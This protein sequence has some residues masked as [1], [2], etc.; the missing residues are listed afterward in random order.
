MKMVRTAV[1]LVLAVAGIVPAQE[2][3]KTIP[4]PSSKMLLAPAPGAPQLTS[5]FSETLA[6]SPD[7]R[8]VAVLNNGYGSA[9][10]A[11]RQSIAILD[12]TTNQLRDFPDPRLGRR[13]RQTFFVGLAF[14]ADGK[15][16]YASMA[17]I[18][19]PLGERPGS[20]GNGIAVYSFEN[21]VVAPQGFL[22]IGL[23]PLRPGQR[24]A[25]VN[26]KIPAGQAI[27]Y[28]AGLA[29]IPGTP[30]KLLVADNLSDDAL[31]LDASDGKIL[32]RFALSTS[33][34]EL[35][36]SYPYAVVVDKVGERAWV[37]LWNASSVVELDLKKGRVGRSIA[38][39]KPKSNTQAGSHPTTMMWLGEGFLL[40]TL[41]NTDEVAVVRPDTGKVIKYLSTTLPKQQVGGAYPNSLAMD[42]EYLFV[43]NASSDA[44]AVFKTD[45]KTWICL[46]NCG[47]EDEKPPSFKASLLGFIPTEWYPT[48]LA[49]KDGDL[50]IATGKA[51][52][53]GPNK[54]SDPKKPT[55]IA[56]LLHGSI[57]RVNIADAL[58]NLPALTREVA[59]SNL[60]LADQQAF[61]F[62]SGQNPI[63]HVIYVIK[64]NRTYDQ[65]FGDLKWGDG[66]PSLVL[67]GEDVTPNHHKLARQFGILDNFYDS[68]EVSGDGHVWSTAAITSDY[69]EKTWQINYR[70]AERTYDFAG[71]VAG[72]IPLD[73]GIPD[74]NEPAT[75]YL[76]TNL[77]RHQL[78]Y[79]DYG[80]FVE[81]PWCNEKLPSK[82]PQQPP[83]LP[84]CP[85]QVVKPGEPLP[86]GKP[87]PWPWPVPLFASA[88]GT[89]PELRGH[90]DAHYAGWNLAYPDQLRADQFLQEFAQFVRDKN[91][92]QFILLYL[93]NDH[94]SGTTPGSQRPAAMVADNDLALGRVI[95]AVS[96]SPYWDD[97]A[98]FVIEDDAQNGGDHV[99]AHRSIA[100]VI[101][102]YSP[103]APD[104]PLVDHTF[105]TTVS[106]V[107]TMEA[108]LGLPPMNNN[109]A[110]APL[111]APLFAGPGT[112]PPFDA[113]F[114][115][116]KNGMIYEV[117]PPKAPG[118][119]ASAQM[120][121]SR[122]DAVDSAVLNQILW[123]DRR[124]DQVPPP[125]PRHNPKVHKVIGAA[126]DE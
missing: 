108:L 47:P 7:G 29:V 43:G 66:D 53:T 69:T 27:P 73:Q 28:P 55:Y 9:E 87:S 85:R 97:T 63:K 83:T 33:K 106:M 122:P 13:A 126:E 6:V 88:E 38:L 46:D 32:K 18:T 4:L 115:N 86:D 15:R 39:H 121:Y 19:D 104:Q 125:T 70:G 1:A 93:P 52:G 89:K 103:G 2:Q 120:D 35:P 67:Y 102:K 75:G 49:V 111:M 112:Q 124:G 5:S 100:L 21:G 57:A 12:L 22:K 42:K 48:A 113:D 24:F 59:E 71:Q 99:D 51:Q 50:L 117:N 11:G 14:S 101:S 81:I 94:T 82:V 68:G 92:P 79:R 45:I 105:Y 116:L 65:V 118:A 31:L 80:E 3:K 17:S 91:L 119:A 54:T 62:H 40:I 36:A 8:Y 64:E 56:T 26:A 34:T 30:E 60:M 96:H 77:A 78:T 44:I 107:H 16:L 110:R 37:S 20:T 114:S 58:K 41:A 90:I 10:S 74:V 25:R 84:P 76:W 61:K 95:E 23:Q 72:E 123:R 98:I 109:D